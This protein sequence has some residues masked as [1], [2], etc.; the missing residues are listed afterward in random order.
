[1]NAAC[2]AKTVAKGAPSAAKMLDVSE[3]S[4]S[5]ET[6]RERGRK[7]REAILLEYYP[8]DGPA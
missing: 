2:Q 5:L 4:P 8:P 1:M 6:H 7:V 3:Y